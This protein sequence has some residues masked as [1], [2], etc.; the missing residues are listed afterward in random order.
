[1][2]NGFIE[3]LGKVYRALRRSS[4]QDKSS[5]SRTESFMY[6]LGYKDAWRFHTSDS[7]TPNFSNREI[8]DYEIGYLCAIRDMEM[9]GAS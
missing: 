4:Q 8:G 1:M 5:P 2:G 3:S 7:L 9:G 6:S